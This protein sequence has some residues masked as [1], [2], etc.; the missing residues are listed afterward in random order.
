MKA[1]DDNNEKVLPYVFLK[2]ALAISLRA[3]STCVRA[4]K[5]SSSLLSLML[6][7]GV[8]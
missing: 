4:N 8:L 7:L 1:E 6:L 3:I 5:T 2:R